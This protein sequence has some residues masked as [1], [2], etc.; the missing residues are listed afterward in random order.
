M[1]HTKD[2][3]FAILATDIVLFTYKEGV[4]CVRLID[5]KNTQD[6]PNMKCLPGGLIHINETAEEA[7]MRI[8]KEKIHINTASVHVEQLRTY[9]AI[10]RDP[11]GRV[12]AVGYVGVIQEGTLT[13]EDKK[14]FV[15][16]SHIKKLAYDHETILADAQTKLVELVMTTNIIFKLIP[17]EFTVLELQKAWET[18]TGKVADKRNFLKKLKAENALKDTKKKQKE[19]AHR[20][21]SIFTHTHKTIVKQDYF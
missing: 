8:L 1:T 13:A 21:S 3:H 11:R 19:G 10:T 7:V 9:S 4:L 14:L 2:L 6:F 18:V 17:N 15:P 16:V 5:C 20:P 12:V